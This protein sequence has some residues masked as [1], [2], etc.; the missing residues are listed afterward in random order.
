MF[1]TAMHRACAVSS[2]RMHG[3]DGKNGLVH[4]SDSFTWSVDMV[5]LQYRVAIGS[6]CGCIRAAGIRC[7]ARWQY[8]M[9]DGERL[10][11]AQFAW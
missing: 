6:R 8:C 10:L 11:T 7:S 9:Y 1:G 4:G 5:P 2:P 3:K